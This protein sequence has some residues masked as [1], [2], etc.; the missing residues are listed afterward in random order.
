MAFPVSSSDRALE[1]AQQR[2]TRAMASVRDLIKPPFVREKHE[3]KTGIQQ[4]QQIQRVLG[5]R[6]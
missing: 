4:V 5:P 3:T 2:A 6:R 1:Q